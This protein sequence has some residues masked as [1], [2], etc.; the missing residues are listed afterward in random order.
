MLIILLLFIPKTPKICICMCATPNIHVYSKLSERINKAYAE[1]H[2]YDFKIFDYMPTDRAPQWCKIKVILDLLNDYKYD[3]LFWIDADAFFNK[4]DIKLEKW[5]SDYEIVICDDEKNSYIENTINTGTM[6]I[7]CSDWN[8]WF[9]Q[10]IWNYKGPLLYAP[11]HEQNVMEQMIKH[12]KVESKIK[13]LDAN[14]FNSVCDEIS[15]DTFVIHLMSY[16]SQ[17]R[18]FYMEKWI[19]KNMTIHK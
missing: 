11:Y 5:I 17:I 13:V 16:S 10:E 9:F 15:D 6:L 1:K 4:H 2:N 12:H 18:R 14:D 19:S 7:K 3:Y 8:K